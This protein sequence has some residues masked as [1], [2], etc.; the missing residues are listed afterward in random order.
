VV[1]WNKF[2]LGSYFAPDSSGMTREQLAARM[3]AAQQAD[4]ECVR[5]LLE[6][7]S[8]E[9]DDFGCLAPYLR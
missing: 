1:D 8:G 5:L 3:L 6:L 2:I 7:H 4:L 9:R